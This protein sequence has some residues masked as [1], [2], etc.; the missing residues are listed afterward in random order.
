M[1]P[2]PLRGVWCCLAR[3]GSGAQWGGGVDEMVGVA[4]R[5]VLRAAG[6]G[7]ARGWRGRDRAPAQER[8]DDL[9]NKLA[10]VIC[11]AEVALELVDGP[12]RERV[13]AALRAAWAAS[14]LVATLPLHAGAA[15]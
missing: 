12:A 3:I 1:P 10:T 15:A 11:N 5:A 9:Q 7:A 8:V 2:D 6:G 14:G 4:R 13:E